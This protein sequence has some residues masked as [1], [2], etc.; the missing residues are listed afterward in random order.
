MRDILAAT[1]K[2]GGI[3]AEQ[4]LRQFNARRF[5]EASKAWSAAT[6]EAMG[7]GDP[8]FFMPPNGQPSYSPSEGSQQSNEQYHPSQPDGASVDFECSTIGDVA[9]CRAEGTGAVGTANSHRN[10]YGTSRRPHRAC[11]GGGWVC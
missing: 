6:E 11:R 4:L 3:S 2:S 7:R 1:G 9:S 10:G 8:V 5:A